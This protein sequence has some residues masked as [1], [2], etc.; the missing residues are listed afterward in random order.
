MPEVWIR[1][2][3]G[4]ADIDLGMPRVESYP[5]DSSSDEAYPQQ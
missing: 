5:P 4:V 2:Y 3:T 1:T